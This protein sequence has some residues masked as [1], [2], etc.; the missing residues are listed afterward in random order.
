MQFRKLAIEGSFLIT[1][2]LFKDKRGMFGRE[3]CYEQINKIL[4]TNP[5]FQV[6][7]TN[8]SFNNRRAH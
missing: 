2:E 1:H 7:Q 5:K 8:I 6:S 4:K 3:F